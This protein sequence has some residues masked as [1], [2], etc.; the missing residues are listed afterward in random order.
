MHH[1]YKRRV[2]QLI[3]TGGLLILAV[4]S[5]AVLLDCTK[6][7]PF[8]FTSEHECSLQAMQT[9]VVMHSS[10]LEMNKV[11]MRLP[12]R[13]E[14]ATGFEVHHAATSGGVTV[15]APLIGILGALLTLLLVKAKSFNT[16]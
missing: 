8:D 15:S 2:T 6:V 4:N 5:N 13:H 14:V 10:E 7:L 11:P 3:L 12:A 1:L 16:K 9:S